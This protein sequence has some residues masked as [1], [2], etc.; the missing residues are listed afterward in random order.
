MSYKRKIFSLAVSIFIIGI[1]LI[2]VEFATGWWISRYSDP[3]Q[4][5]RRVLKVDSDLGWR[6][7]SQLHTTFEG[8]ELFTDGMGLRRASDLNPKPVNKKILVL[9]PSSAFGWGVE[10][11]QAWPAKIA[12]QEV[13]NASQIGHSIVQGQKLYEIL[14]N[15]G[16][17]DHQVVIIAY[18]VN[19]VDRFRFFD[20]QSI[21]DDEYFRD[22]LNFPWYEL[23]QRS[24]IGALLLRGYQEASI[25]LGCGY[26]QTPG[27]RVGADGF[28]KHLHRFLTHLQ[29]QGR[30]IILVNSANVIPVEA[31]LE[32]AQKSDTL[33]LE[34]SKA[35]QRGECSLS[36]RL[37]FEAKQYESW[38]VK[39]D[40]GKINK[41]MDEVGKEMNVSV[42]D[43]ASKLDG[44]KSLFVDPI[45]FSDKG[46]EIVAREIQKVLQE[47][48]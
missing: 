47:L 15:S 48:K 39:R 33:Y 12:G 28:K 18:G 37:F 46:H 30:K 13:L 40:I 21:S 17:A 43:I 29:Q 22:S 14:Q 31:N 8:Q 25:Y 42:V 10:F 19:D 7:R 9:G 34:S 26:D 38:R 35:S 2:V 44:D 45:H 1:Q 36:R 11:E 27:Q 3:L 6:S 4:R 16:L 32:K 24:A 41:V 20:Q 23:L 5:A